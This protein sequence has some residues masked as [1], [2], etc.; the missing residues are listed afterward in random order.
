MHNVNW[1]SFAASARRRVMRLMA[2]EGA[3]GNE[4]AVADDV[5]G[6]LLAAGASRDDIRFDSAHKKSPIKGET[7]NLIFKLPGAIEAP[8]RMLVAHLDTV[9]ICV[10]SKPK[11]DGELVRSAA[12]GRGIG[13]DNRAGTAVLLSTAVELLK[14]K[15]PHPPLTFLWTVQEEV[16]LQGARNIQLSALGKPVLA[17]NWDGGA[18]SKVTVGATGGYR[19][20]ITVTGLASHAGV[21]P[22]KG[23][24]AIAIASL[25]IADLHRAG[26]HGAVDKPG[27]T[28]TSNFGTI[29]A[30]QA[31]NVVADRAVILAEARSH[32]PRFRS[33]IVGEMEAAFERAAAT[34][35]SDTHV[36]GRIEFSG[37]LDYESFRLAD[38]QPCVQI[39]ETALRSLGASPF[40]AIANGGLDANW[41]TAHGI[42]TVTLGCGQLGPH[43]AGEALDLNE[44]DLACR[45]AV[46]LATETENEPTVK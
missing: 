16:G 17:F 20:E 23:V 2:I 4:Q 10:G 38:D 26:W 44:F 36:H 31:T 33:E 40:R 12:P 7:G 25:A 27:G 1:K 30:G 5:I 21:A 29:A 22:E 9:P 19:M 13:A 3:S 35:R 18:A 14:R 37:R 45:L 15:P 39:A 6:E 8:R 32:D 42:P 34:V 11:Q 46:I 28:G 43:T 41:L 24:S